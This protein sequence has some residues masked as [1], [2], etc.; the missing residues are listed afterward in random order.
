MISIIFTKDGPDIVDWRFERD[1]EAIDRDDALYQ[2]SVW[3]EDYEFHTEQA[4]E[5]REKARNEGGE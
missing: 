5:V 1:G 3:H 2:I 4:K